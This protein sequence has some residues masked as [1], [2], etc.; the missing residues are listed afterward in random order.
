[1]QY[2]VGVCDYVI[3][4]E[5]QDLIAMITQ[6]PVSDEV[7]LAFGMLSAIDF[8]DQAVF[9]A[10]KIHDVRSDGLL[11]DEFHAMKES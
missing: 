4:P 9:P 3:V 1:L 8:D 6:P 10:N 7:A 5:T 2:A 11:P